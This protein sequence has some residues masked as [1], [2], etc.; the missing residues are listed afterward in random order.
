MLTRLLFFLSL[1]LTVAGL[2]TGS[3]T[4]SSSPTSPP[5]APAE[6]GFVAKNVHLDAAIVGSGVDGPR[7]L[8]NACAKLR[9][10]Y[11][12]WLK[13][14]V[15]QTM[16]DPESNFVAEGFLQRGPKHCAR[17]ELSIGT[18][19]RHGRLLVVSDGVVVALVR[20]MPGEKPLVAVEDVAANDSEP[21][22]ILERH[23]AGGPLT[24][25]EQFRSALKN[26]TLQTGTIASTEV[27]QIKGDLEPK[28]M[29]V[30]SCTA[31]PVHAGYVYLDAKTLWPVRMEWCG[32]D[33]NQKMCR[34]LRIEFLDP[35]LNQPLGEAECARLFS[36][37]P[38]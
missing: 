21:E 4:R 37:Q 33:R 9:P 5:L 28:A 38:Q 20:E 14:K 36:Y 13:T 32:R 24:L 18:A 10:L 12:G 11:G 1:V 3:W 30:C 16:T 29:P 17:L 31:I 25:L 6:D 23:G 27:I 2:V 35:E 8:K 34:V 19:G 26:P 7:L 22:A 15:R